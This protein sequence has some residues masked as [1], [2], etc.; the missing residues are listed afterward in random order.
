MNP[1]Q[2]A[3]LAVMPDADRDP[4]VSSLIQSLGEVPDG[5]DGP[6]RAEEI[7][8]ELV[9][10]A[11]R[12]FFAVRDVDAIQLSSGPDGEFVSKSPLTRHY[13]VFEVLTDDDLADDCS[14]EDVAHLT[15]D[16]PFV[17]SFGCVFSRR[18]SPEEM[19]SAL[20]AAGSDPS[21]FNL[22]ED[23]D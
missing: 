21:F 2:R 8:G 18:V 13:F 11:I 10:N 23:E 6:Q 1:Y 19:A 14:L 22:I 16:G 7:A 9:K 12:G 4:A 17:G 15:G 5:P 3:V 20:C